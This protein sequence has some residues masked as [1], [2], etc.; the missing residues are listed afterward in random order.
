MVHMIFLSSLALCYT[1][2]CTRSVQLIFS[3]LSQHSISE[4]SRYFWS[5]SWSLQVSAPYKTMFQVLRCTSFF[6][7]LKYNFQAKRVFLF[8]TCFC[9]DN[10]GLDLP[11][12]SWNICSYATQKLNY[13]TFSICTRDGYLE[14]LITLVPPPPTFIAIPHHLPKSISLPMTPCNTVSS[15]ASSRRSF[16]YFRMRITCP[17]TLKSP[18][19]SIVSLVTNSLYKFNRIGNKQHPCLTPLPNFTLHTSLGPGELYHSGLST[20]HWRT[21]FR[22][23]QSMPDSISVCVNLVQF[24]GSNA[25]CQSTKHVHNLSSMS[26]VRSGIILSNPVHP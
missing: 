9:H 18:N 23:R 2:F 25:F 22:S 24:T 12:S 20:F 6:L 13:S 5:T 14:I 26:E 15:L 16:A 19:P 21:F 11:C 4:L 10:A 8:E 17:P 1:S 3:I 7:K